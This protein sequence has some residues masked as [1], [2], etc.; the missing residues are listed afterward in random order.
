MHESES[1][2]PFLTFFPIFFPVFWLTVLFLLSRIGGW[3]RLAEKYKCDDTATINW[4]GFC[5]GMVGAVRYRSCLWI[6][7]GVE[8]LYLKTGPLFLYRAF[9]QPLRIP[10]SAVESLSE[11]K[12]LWLRYMEVKLTGSTVKVSLLK[13]SYLTEITR[14]IGA[15]KIRLIEAPTKT[16]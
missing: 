7:T 5:S 8:G 11:K 13:G 6:G 4:H 14:F 10:W 16:D 3:G 1:T 15:E 9:H 2:L 12:V